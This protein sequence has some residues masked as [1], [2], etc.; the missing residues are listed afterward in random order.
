MKTWK[1]LD[2]G[3]DF[4]PNDKIPIPCRH[5]GVDA[6]VPFRSIDGNPLIAMTSGGGLIFD[7]PIAKFP[8]RI[9]PKVIEC[10]YCKHV[11]I[12]DDE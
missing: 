8:F 9:L 11:F 10:R 2:P 3:D 7:R 6:V 5:C 12:D 4:K 1:I